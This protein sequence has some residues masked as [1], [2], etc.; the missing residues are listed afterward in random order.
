MGGLGVLDSQDE[1]QFEYKFMGNG[2]AMKVENFTPAPMVDNM[3][4]NIGAVNE[5]R[6][7]IE[8]E[9]PSGHPDWF[10]IRKHDIVYL[11]LGIDPGAAKLA[12]E[13]VDIETTSDIPPYTTRYIMNRRDDLHIPAGT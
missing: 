12:F 1:E 7:L 13:V 10:D 6:F 11:L 3:D 2:Y 5:F 4:A 9:E 8:P